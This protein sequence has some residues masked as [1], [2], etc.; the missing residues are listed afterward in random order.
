VV[1]KAFNPDGSGTYADVIKGIG[2]IVA[3]KAKYNIRILNASFSA[4][5]RSWYWEDPLN[6]AIMKA[7][8]AGI[9]VVASAG[10]TGPRPMTVGVP[11]NNPYVITV[12]AMT[13]NYT[14]TNGADDRLAS[15]SA[16]GPTYE[17]FVKPD[18][19]AP[20][21]HMLA[22]STEEGLLPRTY[23]HF[24]AGVDEYFKMSGTSQAAAVVSGV[25]ALILEA[26]PT[27][28]PDAVKCA[29]MATARRPGSPTAPLPT[30]P[31]SRVLDWLRPTEPS[32]ANSAPAPT[33]GSISRAI[34]PEP[35]TT[36]D[37]P[38]RIA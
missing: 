5:V 7:W 3:N 31:S 21:G 33:R 20:G 36:R 8:K 9:V 30:A 1:V 22:P 23:S 10:N 34:F 18:V 6:K 29:V 4:P 38:R 24:L 26:N 25:A 14:P 27:L 19:V 12:D 16:T 13:D 35:T 37:R 15:F 32:M 2:W 28:T 17:G 11:G